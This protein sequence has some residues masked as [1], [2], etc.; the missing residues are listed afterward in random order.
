[1]YNSIYGFYFIHSTNNKLFL[2]S[3]YCVGSKT[4]FFKWKVFKNHNLRNFNG[5]VKHEDVLIKF[6]KYTIF[7]C[8]Y[9]RFNENKNIY[10]YGLVAIFNTYIQWQ[11]LNQLVAA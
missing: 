8:V 5:Y 10:I 7:T 4:T 9:N 1:M 6:N 2:L 3:Y 11:V